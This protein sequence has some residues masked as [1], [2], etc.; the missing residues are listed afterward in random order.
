MIW[1]RSHGDDAG[2]QSAA[3][4]KQEGSSGTIVSIIDRAQRLQSPAVAAYVRRMRS[5]HPADTP[6][7]II[8][9]LEKRYLTTVMS[10]GGA[11]GA[12]AAVP[13]VGTIA[14]IAAIGGES[15][16]FVEASALLALAVAEVHGIPIDHAERRKTLVLAVV[17]GE[18]GVL[19]LG[20][21]LGSKR[22]PLKSMAGGAIPTPALNN[23]NKALMKRIIKKYAARRA[24][25]MIGKMLPAGVGAAIGGA[26]N[27]ALGKRII[28]N[29]TE[30]F[31]PP[32]PAW[33][34]EGT[35]VDPISAL[36]GPDD[37]KGP[38]NT[39]RR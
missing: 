18:E 37:E 20:K 21:A 3:V 12:T 6:A 7:Q 35:V 15:A 14:S 16:F 38:A 33:T 24:P 34:I 22:N 13:G 2:A 9:R 19:A 26:G 31:G 36:P 8:E 10:S 30:A 32:P 25:L 4:A 5:A 17:L 23:L 11:A 27:R 29:A 1:N 39:G 28:A